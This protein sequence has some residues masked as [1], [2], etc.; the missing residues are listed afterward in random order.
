MSLSSNRV[1][2]ARVVRVLEYSLVL[3]AFGAC[4][5]RSP[6]AYDQLG[7][8]SFPGVQLIPTPT[9]GFSMRILSGMVGN[10]QPL[11]IVDG[12]RVMVEPSRG[13]DWFQP[14]DILRIQVLKNASE[15]TVY[16]PEGV[17]GVILITTKQS[18]RRRGALPPS[19]QRYGTR[20]IFSHESA[21]ANFSRNQPYLERVAATLVDQ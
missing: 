17:N 18:M 8:R 20:S 19:W 2:A 1:S 12:K 14:Q 4:V 21:R 15:T 5:Y 9:G 13:I 10:G 3:V 16:G 6:A 11:Y 7:P